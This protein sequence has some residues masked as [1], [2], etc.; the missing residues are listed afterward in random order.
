MKSVQTIQRDFGID[1]IHFI[2]RCW[3]NDKSFAEK[4]TLEDFN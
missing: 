1:N 4:N 3:G 2:K